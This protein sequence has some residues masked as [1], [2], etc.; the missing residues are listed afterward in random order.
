MGSGFGPQDAPDPTAGG[1]PPQFGVPPQQG[2]PPQQGFGQPGP[3]QGFGQ[4][5]PGQGFG[6]GPSYPEASQAV[7]ALVVSIV[8]LTTCCGLVCPV[9]WYLGSKEMEAIDAGRRDPAQ[10][11]M[12][13]A[14]KIIGI[15]GTVILVLAVLFY[16]GL[17]I[18]GVAG[19][20]AGG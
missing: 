14:A 18:L 19:A 17:I 13:N 20:A 2:G 16:G 8:G 5:G 4:P 3:G 15:I 10:R 7:I 6:Y 1:Q 12:A 9:G 11:G